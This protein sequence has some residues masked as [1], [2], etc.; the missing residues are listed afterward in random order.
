MRHFTHF[1]PSFKKTYTAAIALTCVAAITLSGCSAPDPSQQSGGSG[2][3]THTLLLDWLPNPDHSGIYMAET[4]GAF[5]NRGLNVKVQTPSGTADAAKMVS[6][7]QIDVAIS[8]EPDTILAASQGM[9]VVAV[10]SLIPTVLSSLIITGK[11]KTVQDLKGMKVG[12]PSLA[13]SVPTLNYVLQQHGMQPGDVTNVSLSTGLDQ[14]I[15]AGKVDAVFGAYKNIEGVTLREG[16]DFTIL[17]FDQIGVPAFDELVLIANPDRLQSD[18]QYSEFVQQCLSALKDGFAAASDDPQA[19]F[20]AIKP[21]AEGYDEAQLKEIT[22]NT[23][24]LYNNP[25]GFGYMDSQK[26]DSYAQWMFENKLIEKQIK[27]SDAMTMDY[28]Q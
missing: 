26:W 21:D 22:E 20:E 19:A 7:G 28:L 5:K 4:T 18:K 11:D 15:L 27:G 6:T 13:S 1:T 10:A 16:G 8:Y 3:N 12:N 25:N 24:P 2:E 23:V 14:P 9:N 17:P